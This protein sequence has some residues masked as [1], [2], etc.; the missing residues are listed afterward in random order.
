MTIQYLARL[1]TVGCY[2]S[3]QP[4]LLFRTSPSTCVQWSNLVLN[5]EG[6]KNSGDVGK[7]LP[8]NCYIGLCSY[9]YGWVDFGFITPLPA[10]S[11]ANVVTPNGNGLIST[12][13]AYNSTLFRVGAG[14]SLVLLSLS[15]GGSQH[16]T[17]V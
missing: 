3:L 1:I 6:Q 13:S 4:G 7:I 17:P 14:K 16:A 9:M 15:L 2:R 11:P 5:S 12:D 10:N 8:S